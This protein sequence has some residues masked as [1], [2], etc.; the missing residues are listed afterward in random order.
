MNHKVI[1]E[2]IINQAKT[3]N[4]KRL[5]KTNVNYCYYENHHILPKCLGG[6]NNEENL[7]LLTAREH[8]ICHKLLTYIYKDNHSIICA[9]HRMSTSK[10]Y[11]KIVSNRDYKY[12]SELFKLSPIS[13]ETREKMSKSQTRI[14]EFKRGDLNPARKQE[15]KDNISKQLKGIFKGGNNP[16]AKSSR[17]RE[18]LKLLIENGITLKGDTHEYLR[19]KII[20]INI[21][22]GE[23]QIF[24]GVQILL[25]TLNINK[26]KYYSHLK[27]KK[28]I[29][30]TYNCSVF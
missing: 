11:G 21:I 18:N 24:D 15:T 3:L 29:L 28:P 20:C 19:R 22:T 2:N 12:A 17:K 16:M 9:F 30:N 8:F 4:R 27:D 1:Y 5:R 10:R 14:S 23:Q 7:I 6:L 26:R 13:D 25:K